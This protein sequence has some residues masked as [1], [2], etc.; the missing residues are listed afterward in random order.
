MRIHS[1]KTFRPVLFEG[2]GF[3]T[4]RALTGMTDVRNAMDGLLSA[5]GEQVARGKGPTQLGP[6]PTRYEAVLAF[7]ATP[8]GLAQP[9]SGD[10]LL[11]PLLVTIAVNGNE[12]SFDN[13]GKKL[14]LKIS[15]LNNQQA[16]SIQENVSYLA[17][18]VGNQTL[19]PGV[20]LNRL[21][22]FMLK[23]LTKK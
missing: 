18:V 13:Q 2:I 19:V 3:D 5:E 1:R 12:I 21:R 8:Q 9:R 23:K 16:A 4:R 20:Q 11:P 10:L 7:A 17:A 14:L 6:Q 15:G 22:Y